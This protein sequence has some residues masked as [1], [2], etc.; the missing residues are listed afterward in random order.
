M[1]LEPNHCILEEYEQQRA[2]DWALEE[3]SQAAVKSAIVGGDGR[4]LGGTSLT[5]TRRGQSLAVHPYLAQSDLCPGVRDG[6]CVF[7]LIP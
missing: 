6:W 3:S 7:S 1:T 5:E 2:S 4:A